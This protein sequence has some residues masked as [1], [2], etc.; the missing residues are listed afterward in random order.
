M[1]Q[2]RYCFFWKPPSPFSQWTASRFTLDGV[3]YEC[4][5]QFMMHAKALLFG[6]GDVARRVL[7]TTL[8][9]RQQQLG[10]EVRGFERERWEAARERIVHAGNRAKFTQNSDSLA[11]LRATRGTELVEASPIDRIW[12]IGLSADD[13]RALD[14]AQWRGAN[15]LGAI[16]T[17]LRDELAAG[18]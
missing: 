1:A 12:G 2:T 16:L 18:R 17:R 9:A 4:A 14:R 10:R 15:L 6:D 13:P 7:A 11:A 3:E 5:E 8:P